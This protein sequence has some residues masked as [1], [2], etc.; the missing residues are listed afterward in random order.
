MMG[1]LI[2]TAEAPTGE[3]LQPEGDWNGCHFMC[4]A[5][6]PALAIDTTCILAQAYFK[7]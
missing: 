4:S 7:V 5:G 3:A 1:D 6:A 2:T